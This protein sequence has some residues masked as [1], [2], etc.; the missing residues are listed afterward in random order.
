LTLNY[1]VVLESIAFELFVAH[2]NTQ[3]ASQFF[4]DFS[5]YI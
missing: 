2:D 3:Q 1:S 5:R 4:Q